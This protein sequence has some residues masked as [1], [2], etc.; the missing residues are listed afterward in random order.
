MRINHCKE[1][2]FQFTV[3]RLTRSIRTGDLY[4]SNPAGTVIA[5]SV[6]PT[7][8]YKGFSIL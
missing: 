7:G 3:G 5:D 6:L 2:L 1:G 4:V 8:R